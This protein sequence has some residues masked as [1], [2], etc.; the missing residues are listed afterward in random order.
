[1]CLSR[2][3]CASSIPEERVV[4]KRIL[5]IVAIVGI[6]LAHGAVLYKI[7][8]GVHSADTNHVMASSGS[9]RAAYW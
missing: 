6:A 3:I 5:L 9:R 1:V 7:D 2:A 4:L 8:T